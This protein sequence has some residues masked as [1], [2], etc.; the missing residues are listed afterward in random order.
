MTSHRGVRAA[1]ALV[2]SAA[3]AAF[4]AGCT[5]SEQEPTGQVPNA[6]SASSL[7]GSAVSVSPSLR[8]PMIDLAEK[9]EAGW[10]VGSQPLLSEQGTATGDYVLA[11]S[12]GSGDLVVT[13]SCVGPGRSTVTGD[14]DLLLGAPCEGPAS[15]SIRLPEAIL[16][17]TITVT[18]PADYWLVIAP[19]SPVG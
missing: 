3:L 6:S 4:A 1:T 12:V 13:V 2:V 19:V 5:S 16:G 18:A 8:D 17:T 10:S 15:G 7:A 9:V 11:E 14:G